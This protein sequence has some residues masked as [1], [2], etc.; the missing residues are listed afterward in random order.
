MDHSVMQGVEA[1][2]RLL[3]GEEEVTWRHP[4]RVNAGGR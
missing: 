2:N 1:V 4:D 3:L